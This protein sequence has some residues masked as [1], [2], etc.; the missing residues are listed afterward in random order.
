[1]A[2]VKIVA[3]PDFPAQTAEIVTCLDSPASGIRGRD[4]ARSEKIDLKDHL[5]SVAIHAR[6]WP[7]NRG[8]V[9]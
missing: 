6:S 9:G 3:S 7:G 5:E 4:E 1:M 2:D 8:C